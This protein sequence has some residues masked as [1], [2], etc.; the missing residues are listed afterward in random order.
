MNW[1]YLMLVLLA[2]ALLLITASTAAADTIRL[3]DGS[4]ID[5]VITKVEGGKVYVKME[6]ETKTLDIL[7]VVTMDFNT[8][9]LVT[10]ADELPLEHFL[11]DKEAQEIVKNMA[12]L[13]K[14]AS[15]IQRLMMQIKSYW[16]AK[17]PIDAQLESGW[18]AA[19]E[20]FR[21]PL[22]N[23]QE[24]L[25][26]LYLHMLARVDQYNALMK[27][28]ESIYVGIKGLRIGSALVP[29]E[30]GR[31][32]LRKYVP[33]SWYDTVYYEGYNQG[34][35]DSQQRMFRQER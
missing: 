17:Q 23:Y 30:L 4:R 18:I 21:A 22:E 34:F 31:L 27:D 8:P 33:N 1:K 26:D 29:P 3:K 2:L 7:D 20:T 19:K 12:E 6:T 10:D 5:G 13:D 24:I 15:E 14:A 16:V 35:A 11:S 9:H 28:A 32:P 25:N